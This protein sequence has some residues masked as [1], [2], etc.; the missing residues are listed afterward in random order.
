MFRRNIYNRANGHT[1]E[2]DER[3]AALF[4]LDVRASECI[5]TALEV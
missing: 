5:E 4:A 3:S 1:N 2:S